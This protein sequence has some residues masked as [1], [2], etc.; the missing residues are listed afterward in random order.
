MDFGGHKSFSRA[1]ARSF[2]A[3]GSASSSVS[4]SMSSQYCGSSSSD[5]DD[6]FGYPSSNSLGHPTRQDLIPHH[7]DFEADLAPDMFLREISPSRMLDFEEQSLLWGE[8]SS[9]SAA[10]AALAAASSSSFS[11]DI[12]VAELISS[13]LSPSLSL[14]PTSASTSP[15]NES[16]L[17]YDDFDV[18]CSPLSYSSNPYVF[19]P[20]E[21]NLYH[22]NPHSHSNSALFY[23]AEQ[24][25]DYAMDQ[26][27]SSPE[28]FQFEDMDMVE[29]IEETN[30]NSTSSSTHDQVLLALSLT[31]FVGLLVV[32]QDPNN[33]T[34]NGPSFSTMSSANSS[35]P[36]SNCG[37]PVANTLSTITTI[38]AATVTNT[39]Q[40]PYQHPFACDTCN[41]VFQ[42]RYN[43]NVH[44]MIHTGARPYLCPYP[45]CD[46]DFIRKSDMTRHLDTIHTGEKRHKC[47]MGCGEMFGR[48]DQRSKHQK[49]C[50]GQPQPA[51]PRPPQFSSY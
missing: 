48:T 11:N 30:H 40:A 14:S 25:D 10:A 23:A 18:L 50:N 16:D 51:Q 9:L 26:D 4:P 38:A 34:T 12:H 27:P 3:S 1:P 45:Y 8:E 36:V 29:S 22:S 17:Q 19:S 21:E 49:T 46:D 32:A 31:T 5:E 2:A 42:Q 47:K 20:T 43:L 35:A 6:F 24:G 7:S 39:P 13:S 15:S 33:F 37:S 28:P 41:Q 44:R